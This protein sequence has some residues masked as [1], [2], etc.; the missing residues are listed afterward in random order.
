[1]TG[2]SNTGYNLEVFERKK[3]SEDCKRKI[4]ELFEEE[5]TPL[6]IVNI[7]RK[8]SKKN[9]TFTKDEITNALQ[10]LR[11]SGEVKFKLIWYVDEYPPKKTDK[12]FWHTS[13]VKPIPVLDS[14]N[15]KT[16]TDLSLKPNPFSAHLGP[17]K[18]DETPGSHLRK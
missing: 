13:T 17:N 14:K 1:M 5:K 7:Q 6:H 16:F 2:L 11:I 12:P 15:P 10:D 4:L 18:S 8:L 3:K 9:E